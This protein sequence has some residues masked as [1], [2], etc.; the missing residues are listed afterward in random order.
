MLALTLLR[1][2][3]AGSR[4][5]R[6]TRPTRPPPGGPGYPRWRLRIYFAAAIRGGRGGE[7]VYPALVAALRRHGEVLTEHVATAGPAGEPLPDREIHDRDIGWLRSADAVVAEV[8]VPSLGVGYEIALAAALGKPVLCLFDTTS[9]RRLSAMIA[10]APGV[11]V[12]EYR[13]RDA[14]LAAAERFL[15]RHRPGRPGGPD[16]EPAPTG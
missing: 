9:G 5:S 16:G 2:R 8:T 3:P 14:A 12:A 13:D 1:F 7:A 11:E 15:E 4:L 6:M 10:G